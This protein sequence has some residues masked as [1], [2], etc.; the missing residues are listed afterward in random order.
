MLTVA[1]MVSHCGLEAAGVLFLCK[2]P[3]QP[4]GSDNATRT[5]VDSVASWKLK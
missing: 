3:E 4:L 2:T 5:S 1:N